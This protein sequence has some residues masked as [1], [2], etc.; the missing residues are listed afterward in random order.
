MSATLQVPMPP[1][2]NAARQQR[3]AER[4][5]SRKRRQYNADLKDS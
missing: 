3:A 2:V 4:S 5:R 1:H